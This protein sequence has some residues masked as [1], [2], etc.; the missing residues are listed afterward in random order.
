MSLLLTLAIAL[1]LLPA[2][3]LGLPARAS[4]MEFGSTIAAGWDYTAII[5]S[6]GSLWTWGANNYGQLG[7]VIFINKKMSVYRKFADG[8]WSIRHR[9]YTEEKND[10]FFGCAGI[11]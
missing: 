10:A 1:T 11:E 7:D 2:G 5:K 9:K 8:S 3:V 4:G 6:D